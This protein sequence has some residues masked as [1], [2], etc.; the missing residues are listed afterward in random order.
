MYV[1]LEAGTDF[2][3]S[4]RYGYTVAYWIIARDAIDRTGESELV[5]SRQKCIRFLERK[6]INFEIEKLKMAEF[7]RGYSLGYD[8]VLRL[9]ER[10][11]RELES[12]K[13]EAKP[14]PK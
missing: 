4:D 7:R 1:L 2:L 5:K 14:Q 12:R 13:E 9:Q 11:K 6:G 10:M 8:D 3:A